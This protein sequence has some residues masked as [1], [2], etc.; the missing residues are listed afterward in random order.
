[1]THKK[2][3]GKRSGKRLP[4]SA[5]PLIDFP[6]QESHT[7]GRPLEYRAEFVE[8]ARIACSLGATDVEVAER[9]GVTAR[10]VQKWRVRYPEFADAMMAGKEYADARVVRS[11]YLRAVGYSF[12]S[13][14]I[15]CSN[16]QVTR[17]DC[18]E[19]VP[20]DP[21]SIIFWLKNRKPEEWRDR[22]ELTGKDGEA[23]NAAP[24]VIQIVR[25]SDSEAPSDVEPDPA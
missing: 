14:E 5:E 23:L 15:F 12:E 16:G 8:F 20:P 19:H 4:D 21:T 3:V 2:K 25:Y 18:V 11:L 7:N 9:L 6:S 24:P 10:C 1:M 22:R 17:V 13:E